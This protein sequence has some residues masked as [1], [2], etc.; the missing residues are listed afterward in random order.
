MAL[1]V[2]AEVYDEFLK[3]KGSAWCK[4]WEAVP[5]NQFR[6]DAVPFRFPT[7]EDCRRAKEAIG[8]E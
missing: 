4:H 6:D 7:L 5:L 8:G 3:A 2:F 1:E